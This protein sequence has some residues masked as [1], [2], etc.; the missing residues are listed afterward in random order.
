MRS[1]LKQN[2]KDLLRVA[3]ALTSFDLEPVARVNDP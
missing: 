1:P 3:I 2:E